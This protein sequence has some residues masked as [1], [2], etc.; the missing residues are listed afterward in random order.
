M[1]V[2][3]SDQKTEV[4]LKVENRIAGGNFCADKNIF[5][6]FPDGT[7]S[8]LVSSSGI[9]VCPETYKFNS[10]GEKLDFVLTFFP[11]KKG[12]E[13]IDLIEDCS[14]NCFSFYGIIVDN[15][16]N[17]KIDDAFV[18]AENEEPSKALVSFIKIAE[19]TGNKN[20]GA[21][22]LLYMNIVKLSRITGN[23]VKAAEWYKKLESSGAPG[24]QLYIKHLS[25]QGIKY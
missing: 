6:I 9:P 10:I 19:E 17:K 21:T 20:P 13:W 8:L 18:L 1:K 2:V 4:Y 25:S 5:I 3:I 22:G 7:R 15:S 16:L 14:E 23:N 12:T 24:I 11:L